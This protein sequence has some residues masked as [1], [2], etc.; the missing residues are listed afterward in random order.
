MDADVTSGADVA[1]PEFDEVSS[2]VDLAAVADV[3]DRGDARPESVDAFVIGGETPVG[4]GTL[5]R[6]I[7]VLKSGGSFFVKKGIGE[8]NYVEAYGLKREQAGKGYWK[9]T[10]A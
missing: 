3:I 9:Y 4:P 2:A 7:G 5:S 10:K 8:V 1:K 6:A